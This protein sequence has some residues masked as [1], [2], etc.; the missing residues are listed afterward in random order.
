MMRI[1]LTGGIAAGKSVVAAR[2]VD[3]GAVL[4]DSD[5]IV[6]QLQAPGQAG[7]EA[8]VA[9]FGPRMLTAAG[10]LDRQALGAVVFD[11]DA[12]RARLNAVI[13]P[14]VRQQSTDLVQK[15]LA[16]RG[17]DVVFVHDIPLLVETGQAGDFDL[18][19]VVEAPRELR[20]QRMVQ[21]RGMA[22]AEA[23]ARIDAQATDAQRRVAADDLLINDGTTEELV[24]AVDEWW[25]RRVGEPRL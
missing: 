1:G 2:L 7:L 19:L 25:R 10:D 23:A 4:I 14:L 17:E 20:I 18:V 16:E 3:L 12:A 11:D 6:R 21:R 13:H 24:D 22:E 15:T 8:I 5:A 9:E